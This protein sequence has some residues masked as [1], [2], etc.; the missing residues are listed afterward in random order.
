MSLKQNSLNVKIKLFFAYYRHEIEL[1]GM[2]YLRAT[3][4]YIMFLSY[5]TLLAYL[6]NKPIEAVFQVI[7]FLFLRYKFNTTYHAQKTSTCTFIT[8]CVIS[9]AIPSTPRLGLTVFG[10]IVTAFVV[11]FLSYLAQ[12]IVD[13]RKQKKFTITN[14]TKEEFISR[15]REVKLTKDCTDIAIAYFYD[16]S[17]KLNDIAV[18]YSI[19]YDSAKRK[20]NRIKH[21][22][23]DNI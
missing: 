3:P 19:D 1:K 2:M 16:K 15:C 4:L 13:A 11:C 9:F 20:V 22:L 8:L 5:I 17:M 14:C 18:Q 21:K 12:V 7:A 10:G 23:L 6:T